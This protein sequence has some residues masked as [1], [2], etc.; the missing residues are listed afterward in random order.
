MVSYD[1]ITSLVETPDYSEKR[2][3]K[4]QVTSDIIKD[5]LYCFKNYN[6]QA[7]PIATFF[8]TGSAK[9]DAKKIYDFIKD[10]IDYEAEPTKYQ[11]TRSFSRIIHDGWGDCKHNA[12]LAASIGWNLGYNVIFRFVS[13]HSGSSYGH[14]YV[15]LQDPKTKKSYIIDPLQSFDYEK[16]YNKK[17]DYFAENKIKNPKKMLSRLTGLGDD[18]QAPQQMLFHFAGVGDIAMYSESDIRGIGRKHRLRDAFKKLKEGIKERGGVFKA[19][20]LQPIRASASML[21]LVNYRGFASRLKHLNER[22]PDAVKAFA[23]KFGYK[24]STVVNQAN[25]GAKQAPLF[26]GKT[27]GISDGEYLQGIGVAPVA[28]AIAA[29]APVI[30]ALAKTFQQHK[31]EEPGDKGVVAQ[32]VEDIQHLPEKDS[33]ADKNNPLKKLS[34]STAELEKDAESLIT[35][36]RTRTKEEGGEKGG[37][38]IMEKIKNMPKPVLIG[39][40]VLV[41]G[42]IYMAVRKK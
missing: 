13:Y 25:K 5:L 35:K 14:V 6:Y 23:K 3:K 28:A 32:A 9:G 4:Y 12:L 37:S 8:S 31:M 19:L 21:L 33:A 22:N 2:L 15:L 17:I 42:G 20:T 26:G 29:A 39:G 18:Q 38:G 27:S 40:A 30:I 24:Y 7:E 1:T 10:N 34:E 36:G 11:T 41:A 16:N